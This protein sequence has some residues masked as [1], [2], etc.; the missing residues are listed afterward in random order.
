MVYLPVGLI[1][2]IFVTEICQND[3]GLLNMSRLN[4]YRC[5]LMSGHLI[6]ILFPCLYWDGIFANL[7][8]I[9]PRYVNP[10]PEQ[11]Y[12]NLKFASE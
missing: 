1:G 2:S 7:M 6:C 5:H 12:M 10:M 4:D 8:T 9:L 3:N 11:V